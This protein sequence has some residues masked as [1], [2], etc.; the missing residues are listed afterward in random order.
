M[1]LGHDHTMVTPNYLLSPTCACIRARLLKPA[2]YNSEIAG[3][4]CKRDG[5]EPEHRAAL[6][7]VIRHR[8]PD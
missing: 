6:E 8:L 1:V 7:E 5:L 2:H 3:T 4:V